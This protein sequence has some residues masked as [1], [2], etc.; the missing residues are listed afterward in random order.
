MNR[1]HFQRGA[2]GH[3]FTSQTRTQSQQSLKSR[4]LCVEGLE[5]RQLLSAT[6]YETAL[7][8]DQESVADLQICGSPIADRGL[9]TED[10]ASLSDTINNLLREAG[11][12]PN[13]VSQD[14]VFNLSSNPSSTFTIFLDFDGNRYAGNLWTDGAGVVT[15]K[16]D[17]DGNVDSFS[18]SELC[19]I[20]NVWLRVSED[21]A[22]FNVNVTTKDPGAAALSKSSYSDAS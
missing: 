15:P 5:D 19:E 13:N 12:N 9:E 21:Y 16:F 18:N 17:R 11:Q 22:P 4:K 3:F 1:K 8:L 6:P 2:F 7:D 20:Y 14:F 10:V